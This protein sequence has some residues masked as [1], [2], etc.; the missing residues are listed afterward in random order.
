[1]DSQESL[2]VLNFARRDWERFSK[3]K[4]EEE[5]G[6]TGEPALILAFSYSY[7]QI[8][9][10]IFIG[11]RC[12]VSE[13][14]IILDS[15]TKDVDVDHLVEWGNTAF[16]MLEHGVTFFDL[17]REIVT[18]K[19]SKNKLAL[20]VAIKVWLEEELQ[21]FKDDPESCDRRITAFVREQATTA[22]PEGRHSIVSVKHRTGR[23]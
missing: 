6:E 10:Y 14:C 18:L 17:P 13:Q 3:N 22:G 15:H 20:I 2:E 5:V 7:Y 19:K 11:P 8:L 1:M 9:I 12:G 23:T 4:V 16:S 21:G